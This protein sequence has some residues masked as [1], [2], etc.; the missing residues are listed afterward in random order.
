[1]SEKTRFLTCVTKP[2]KTWLFLT[3]L[4]LTACISPPQGLEK[5]AFTIQQLSKIDADDYACRCRIV[6][7]G[8]KILSVRALK[9]QTRVEIM[10]LPVSSFSAKPVWD[11]AT[12][13][14][15]IAYLPGFV[16]PE[17]LKSQYITVKGTLTGKEQGKIDQADYH[18]PVVKATAF[19]H[20]QL[21]R[22]Y[23]YAPYWDDD[24]YYGYGF[25]PR[26]GYY[27]GFWHREP[28]VRTILR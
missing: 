1:M 14:R 27:G 9:D 26:W 22:E 25:G 17:S 21:V 4:C 3:A 5:D 28:R 6:R 18:F 15:F 7:L 23:Y 19:K 8:G 24:F 13:G 20:W 10:S 11:G 16:D 2:K 12:D